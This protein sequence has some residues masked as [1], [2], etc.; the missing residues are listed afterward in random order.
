[1]VEHVL[2]FGELI[3]SAVQSI[4]YYLVAYVLSLA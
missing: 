1:M 2:R 3:D 4:T